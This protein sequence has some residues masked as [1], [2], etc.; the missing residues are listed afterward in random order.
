LRQKDFLINVLKWNS[1]A[2]D[3]DTSVWK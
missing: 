1:I 3:E 2:I